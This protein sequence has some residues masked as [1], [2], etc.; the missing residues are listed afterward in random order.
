MI[1]LF[2]LTFLSFLT[3]ATSIDCYYDLIWQDDFCISQDDL[4]SNI[5]PP[6]NILCQLRLN[7]LIRLIQTNMTNITT[8][9]QVPSEEDMRNCDFSSNIETTRLLEV[10]FFRLTRGIYYLGQ[11]YYFISPV[12]N[13]CLQL[14]FNVVSDLFVT[15]CDLKPEC[16]ESV[17]NDTT[18]EF[19]GCGFVTMTKQSISNNPNTTTLPTTQSLT[20]ST[21]TPLTTP[22]ESSFQY[23]TTLTVLIT[24]GA[25]LLI[26]IVITGV[27]IIFT[28]MYCIYL[29]RRNKTSKT[30]DLENK[31]TY[32]K[33]S[34]TKDDISVIVRDDEK[35]PP[36]YPRNAPIIPRK[37]TPLNSDAKV[38]HH[39]QHLVESRL[40]NN[41]YLNHPNAEISC[42]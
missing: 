20:T 16:S 25:F 21:S 37:I 23:N 34:I 42:L 32:R 8:L 3:V 5:L 22:A 36:L 30:E 17:L 12:G 33:K 31:H 19:L 7:S 4:G 40:K 9:Y 41:I 38:L 13:T 15:T 1:W 11:D 10:S 39:L 26:M 24:V 18:Q 6:N 14:S 35:P 2:C 27:L 29:T 28:C